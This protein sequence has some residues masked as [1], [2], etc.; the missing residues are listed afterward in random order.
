M[1]RTEPGRACPLHYRYSPTAFAGQAAVKAEILYV[2]GGLYGNPFALDA[3]LAVA[4]QESATVIFNGDFNWFDI[5]AEGFTRLNDTVLQHVALR[6]NV[7]TEL[8][9]E[10][11]GAGC[12][13]AYPDWV[14]DAEVNR[15]NEIIEMLRE[16]ASAFPRIRAR[17]A[18]L[19]PHLVAQVGA[20]RIGIVHGD[21][22]SLSGWRFSQELLR[23]DP[24]AAKAL[25]K[26][27]AVD[28]FASSHTCL[29]VMQEFSMPRGRV[30]VANNGA[31]GMPNFEGTNYGLATRI[32]LSPSKISLYGSMVGGV[33]V[34]AVP[35]SYDHEAWVTH[36]DRL[37]TK[38]SPASLSYRKRIVSGPAYQLAE[39]TRIDGLQ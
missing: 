4:R 39:A 14:G 8:A 35:I 21:A 36:F 18:A 19:P 17:I 6:G 29:P 5:D 38:T 13:C 28:V 11:Q 26:D 30:L 33:Y 20:V 27:C 12:G 31:A 10:D 37:W 32:A 2:V 34:E 3:I 9:T 1:V 16:T 15:S 7:E 25:L 22:E 24:A 23:D